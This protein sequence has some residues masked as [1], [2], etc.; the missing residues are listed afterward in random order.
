M[1]VK[2]LIAPQ[3]LA[4]LK[5]KE[6]VIILD[7]RSAEEYATSHISDAI[8]VCEIFT[9]LATSTPEGLEGLQSLFT[10]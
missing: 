6:S 5:E 9:H 4:A 2:P 3:E 7:T 1:E 8:N 10:D